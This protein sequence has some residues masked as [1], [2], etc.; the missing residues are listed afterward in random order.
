VKCPRRLQEKSRSGRS[1]SR[2]TRASG[3]HPDW[4]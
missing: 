3:Q 4:L 2:A 1:H